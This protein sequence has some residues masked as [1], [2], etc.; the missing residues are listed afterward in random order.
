MILSTEP[1]TFPP[2]WPLQEGE[3]PCTASGAAGDLLELLSDTSHDGAAMLAQLGAAPDLS[4][5]ARVLGLQLQQQLAKAMRTAQLLQAS[6][7]G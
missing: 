3:T 2:M 7:A 1:S 6:A 4:D 5:Q